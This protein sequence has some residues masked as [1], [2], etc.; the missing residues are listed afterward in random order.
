[1]APFHVPESFARNM[2]CTLIP[3][4]LGQAPTTLS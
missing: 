3:H 1:M 2:G 4:I